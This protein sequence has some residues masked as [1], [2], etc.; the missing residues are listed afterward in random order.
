MR[1]ANRIGFLLRSHVQ[2]LQLLL[3]VRVADI[4]NVRRFRA[5]IE[6]AG[7]LDPAARGVSVVVFFLETQIEDH[8]FQV[9]FAVGNGAPCRVSTGHDAA[10]LGSF[11][12]RRHIKRTAF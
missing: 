4:V 1:V 3:A 9:A 8:V 6:L 5:I 10:A 11:A 12:V 7:L 2:A